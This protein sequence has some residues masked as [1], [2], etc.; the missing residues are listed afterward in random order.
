MV[1]HN[2]RNVESPSTARGGILDSR[3]IEQTVVNKPNKNTPL[4]AAFRRRF[5]CS[6]QRTG[7][8]R[9]KIIIS[10]L[11]VTTARAS[12]VGTFA[13]HAPDVCG[14]QDFWT[15]GDISGYKGHEKARTDRLALEY[16]HKSSSNMT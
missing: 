3:R 1:P 6:V 4:S 15:F 2:T 16:Q 12:N 11:I 13:R 7:I 10:K 9:R 14:S 5:I 8:G